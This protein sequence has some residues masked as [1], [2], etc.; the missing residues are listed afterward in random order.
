MLPIE[1][2]DDRT[3]KEIIENAR[4]AISRLN[5]EWSDEN[6]HD[7][8]I[9]LLELLA[10]VTEIQQYRL[11]RITSLNELKFL[12]LLG[13]K[14]RLARPAQ[15][16]IKFAEAGAG[17]CIPGGTQLT[18]GNLI[19]ETLKKLF[20]HPLT[21]EKIMVTTGKETMDFTSP[22]RYNR[23]GYPVFGREA[24]K[25]N[26]IL[27]GLDQPIQENRQL[28]IYLDLFDAFPVPRGNWN[29]NE[30]K[31][32]PSGKVAWKYFG[33]DGH[34]GAWLP[35]KI[36]NDE[37]MHFSRDGI[38]E[39]IIESPM[40]PLKINPA[41]DKPRYWLQCE[42][43]EEGYET[44][45]RLAQVSLNT[46]RARQT[47]TLC[48]LESLHWDGSE[49]TIFVF[50]DIP[51]YYG[52]NRLQVQDDCG[53]WVYWQEVND[54]QQLAAGSESFYIEKDP[55][56][57]RSRV[58]LSPLAE[59]E[60]NHSIHR[61]I[62]V[63]SYLPQF[64]DK[65]LIGQG[66]G[67]PNEAYYLPE[68]L[69]GVHSLRIQTGS[70]VNSEQPMVWQ[71]WTQVEDLDASGPDDRHFVLDSEKGL[72]YFG[73]DEQGAIPEPADIDN[74]CIIS[75]MTTAGSRGNIKENNPFEFGIGD[76]YPLSCEVSNLQAANGGKDAETLDSAKER[77]L[78]E[79]FAPTRAVTAAD[80]EALALE[81]PGV[82]MACAKAIPGFSPHMP[83]Y[84]E[85]KAEG[86]VSVVVIPYS[87][88]ERPLPSQNLLK[89]VQ[90][91]LEDYRL[92]GSQIHVIPPE[93][94]E[95]SVRAII[96]VRTRDFNQARMVAALDSFLDPSKSIKGVYKWDFNGTVF[97][98]DILAL[99]NKVPGVEYVSELWLMADGSGARV[100]AAG[101]VELPPYGLPVAGSYEIEVKDVNE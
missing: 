18:T 56:A 15:T 81:T 34:D 11:N 95:V 12:R 45:P 62:R 22:N 89:N 27:I 101:D 41:T 13:E 10:W 100:T 5:P 59:G 30:F 31:M 28:N 21:I 32:L 50:E 39:V 1:N 9:T 96:M 49:D 78:R 14:P 67:L 99:L 85:I 80:Y 53:N 26:R 23:S 57:M 84:P 37:S 83:G 7:P 92:I 65:R 90:R 70:R 16:Y 52:I 75:C 42:V 2:L 93:Y 58:R 19:F 3:F 66:N 44:A 55:A 64:V 73:N 86:Q 60:L 76:N 87:D 69:S 43:A 88:K 71:D 61:N 35:V 77:I 20:Y 40:E 24:K 72:I 36:V 98:S 68:G 33:R 8:G 29:E 63:I 94:V 17:F 79:Y 25:G 54:L 91:H 48:N 4:R 46:V 6:F 51:Q 74:I 97:K 38:L 82:R 47:E